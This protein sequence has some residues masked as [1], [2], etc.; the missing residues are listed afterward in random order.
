[1]GR[2]IPSSYTVALSFVGLEHRDTLSGDPE[3]VLPAMTFTRRAF[4]VHRLSIL[5]WSRTINVS[6]ASCNSSASR[7]SGHDSLNTSSI[8]QVNAPISPA[9][10]RACDASSR[11]RPPFLE[12]HHQVGV[13]IAF[14]ISR[15]R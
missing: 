15:Q 11:A 12:R 6:S 1:M 10:S 7:T 5:N 8:A 9:S 2:L 13:R 4:W 3:L 14:K